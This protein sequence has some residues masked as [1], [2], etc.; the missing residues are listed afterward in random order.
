MAYACQLMGEGEERQNTLL[1]RLQ[2]CNVE[3]TGSR[4]IYGPFVRLERTSSGTSEEGRD[5]LRLGRIHHQRLS[6][7]YG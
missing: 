3:S 6:I 1:C 5:H 4:E 7:P 2:E